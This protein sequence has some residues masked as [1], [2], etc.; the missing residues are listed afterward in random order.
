[1][2]Y[3]MQR[4]DASDPCTV[5]YGLF[6]FQLSGQPLL[7]LRGAGPRD[8][9]CARVGGVYGSLIRMR[10]IHVGQYNKP[11]APNLKGMAEVGVEALDGQ[12]LSKKY[13]ISGVIR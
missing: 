1:M 9:C 8:Y 10:K 12:K 3:V 7:I 2:L 4:H 5:A 11:R 6:P 13:L